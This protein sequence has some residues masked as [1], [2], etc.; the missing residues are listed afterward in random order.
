MKLVGSHEKTIDF[1][2]AGT[3]VSLGK[4]GD[5]IALSSFHKAQGYVTVCPFEQ[6]PG[7]EKFYDPEAV[8][9]YRKKPLQHFANKGS[10]YGLFVTDQI[11]GYSAE[12][13]D[14]RFP[15]IC[16]NLAGA[17]VISE[18]NIA[19][20]W[21]VQTLTITGQKTSTT[22]RVRIGGSFSLN[23]ASYTQLTEGSPIPIPEC[24]NDLTLTGGAL[25]ITNPNLPVKFEMRIFRDGLPVNFAEERKSSSSPVEWYNELAISLDP[26][27]TT[28]MTAYYMVSEDLEEHKLP[29]SNEIQSKIWQEIGTIRQFIVQRTFE[30]VDGCCAI[31]VDNGS[32]CLITDHVALPLGWNRDNYF[33]A[34][35]LM[36]LYAKADAYI[37]SD[38][39]DDFK[40]RIKDI[41][42]GHLKWVYE[43]ALRPNGYW[44]RSYIITGR[45][46]DANT[47]QLDQQCY[48]LLELCDYLS[49][50]PEDI[51]LLSRYGVVIDGILSMLYDERKSRGHWIFETSETPAD[52]P[53]D[54]P[55]HFSSNI[56][57]WKSMVELSSWKD[58]LNLS[59]PVDKWSKGMKDDIL[60]QFTTNSKDG[61]AIF[62]YVCDLQGNHVIYQDAND[63]VLAYTPRYGFVDADDPRWV[64]LMDF[65]FSSA[66][67]KGHFPGIYGGLG[68]VHTK[69]PWPLGD[70][71][72]L[73]YS[74]TMNDTSREKRI[75]R[76]LEKIMQWD[77]SFGE[78]IDSTTADVTSKHW[79][80]WP[81]CAISSVIVEDA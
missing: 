68:S 63:I 64:G 53:V 14:G 52:D 6:F 60:Q 7:K 1:G 23:R 80:S 58:Q 12:F 38:H 59:T 57:L 71:Q 62:S 27:S 20:S 66:N 54:Y 37:V 61:T 42:L 72:E 50:W 22:V 24:K 31:P 56:L 77:G 4:Y 78:A 33:Q 69:N 34:R 28:R 43:K 39:V 17:D 13:Q 51:H 55:Y 5:I 70:C 49:I 48:P 32:I 75:W 67:A 44:G 41:C 35:F 3:N 26:G 76:K 9:E 65:G 2:Q 73:I 8:R 19:D 45:C 46:K 79:F 40:R 81:G 15:K 30:Y 11:L 21:V 47:F 29:I 18:F 10:G 25:T 74:R 36:D 16:M